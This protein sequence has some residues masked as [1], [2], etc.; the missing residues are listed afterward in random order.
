[1]L[2][3]WLLLLLLRLRLLLLLLRFRKR[4]DLSDLLCQSRESEWPVG[5]LDSRGD[6]GWRW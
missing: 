5:D 4:N 1:L 2:Q 3:L 6:L